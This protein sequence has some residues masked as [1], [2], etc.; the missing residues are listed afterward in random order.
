VLGLFYDLKTALKVTE[1][2]MADS[3]NGLLGIMAR[4][5]L[6]TTTIA[7]LIGVSQQTVRETISRNELPVR[8]HAREAIVRFVAANKNAKRR[9]EIRLAD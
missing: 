1:N 7:A 8:A 2:I 3:I 9:S 4:L 6:S 5:Q